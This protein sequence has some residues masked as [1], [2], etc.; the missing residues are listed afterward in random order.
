MRNPKLIPIILER[1]SKWGDVS[2][3]AEEGELNF[4]FK[5]P[6]YTQVDLLYKNTSA[7]QISA[8]LEKAVKA[9]E[10]IKETEFTKEN[11]KSSLM[12]IADSLPSRGELLHPVRFALSGLKKSPDPFI[13]AEILGKNETLQRLQNAI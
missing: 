10:E 7:E 11:I 4:F 1:I 5:E 2:Q 3:M 9:L 8:N 13:I 12:Q 6:I